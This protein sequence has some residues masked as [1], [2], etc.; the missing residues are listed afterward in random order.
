MGTKKIIIEIDNEGYVKA[1]ITGAKGAAC[2][3]YITLVEEIVNGKVVDE[4]LTAEYYQQEVNQQNEG[5][6]LNKE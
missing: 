2:K 3:E 4:E 5:Q 6:L 1:E